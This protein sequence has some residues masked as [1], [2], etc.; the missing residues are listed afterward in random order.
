MTHTSD[1]KG[2]DPILVPPLAL[3]GIITLA[4]I[5]GGIAGYLICHFSESGELSDVDC[6]PSVSAVYENEHPARI[7]YAS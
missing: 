6:P 1:H 3:A 7:L 5:V 4:A 2:T